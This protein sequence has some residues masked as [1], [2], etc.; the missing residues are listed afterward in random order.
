MKQ[1][2]SLPLSP[3]AVVI[4]AAMLLAMLA[5]MVAVMPVV[6]L[7]AM[8]SWQCSRAWLRSCLRLGAL[9]WWD[10]VARF[11][12]SLACVGRERILECRY[13]GGGHRGCRRESEARQRPK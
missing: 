4:L 10:R 1:S 11:D 12:E 9:V 3:V 7:A 8:L 2:P 6:F 13:G 5:G